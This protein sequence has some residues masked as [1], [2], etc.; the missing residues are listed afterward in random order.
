VLA[1]DGYDAAGEF[2]AAL[3]LVSKAQG[4]TISEL[5]DGADL[6]RQALYRALSEDGNPEFATLRSV[7]RGLGLKLSVEDAA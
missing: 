1:D 6:G 3:R 5:A 4:L 2:L 7:L